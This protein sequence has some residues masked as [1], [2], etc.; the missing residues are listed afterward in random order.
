[1]DAN[2]W[3]PAITA[4]LAILFFVLLIDQ[5]R[6]RRRAYQAVWALG[7]MKDPQTVAALNGLNRI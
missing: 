3:L 7:Q 1:M 5:W 4:V 6:E 2:V